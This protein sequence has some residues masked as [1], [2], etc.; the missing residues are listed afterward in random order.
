MSADLMEDAVKNG[1]RGLVIASVG[2]G[3]MSQQALDAKDPAQLQ[4]Y[5]AGSGTAKGGRSACGGQRRQ[6]GQVE[7]VGPLVLRARTGHQ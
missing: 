6:F 7:R 1:A 2:D 4:R 5:C 3:N